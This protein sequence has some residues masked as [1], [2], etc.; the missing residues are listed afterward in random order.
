MSRHE[1]APGW[2][3]PL[4]KPELNHLQGQALVRKM[5]WTALV[6]RVHKKCVLEMIEDRARD[7]RGGRRDE[8]RRE[9]AARSASIGR[10]LR[11]LYRSAVQEPIPPEFIQ[12]L[13]K[14]D[15]G[16]KS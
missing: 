13:N 9:T 4:P 5:L 12:L 3:I 2:P 6:H 14:L 16:D 8:S 11:A 1:I 7:M 10:E 15:A